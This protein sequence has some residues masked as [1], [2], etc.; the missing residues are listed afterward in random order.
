M[1]IKLPDTGQR[2]SDVGQDQYYYPYIQRAALY[3][4]VKGRPDGTF[5]PTET[6]N[7][8]DTT[9]MV[10]RAFERNAAISLISTGISLVAIYF[11]L[12]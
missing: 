8:A 2:F 6:I 4:L 5:G 1:A 11:M 12:R 7:R 9:I 3:G 10:V